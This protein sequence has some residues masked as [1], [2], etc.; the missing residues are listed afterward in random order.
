MNNF[1]TGLLTGTLLGVGIAVT[2]CPMGKK[3][4]RKMR[5]RANKMMRSAGRMLKMM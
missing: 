3:E 2:V 4:M 1:S 5:C